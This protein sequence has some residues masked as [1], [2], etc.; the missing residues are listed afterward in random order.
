MMKA[1]RGLSLFGGLAVVLT[2]FFVMGCSNNTP[3]QPN[4]ANPLEMGNISAKTISSPSVMSVETYDSAYIDKEVGGDIEIQRGDYVHDFAVAADGL[5]ESTLITVRSANDQILGKE[6]I[7]FEF[8]PDGLVF[9]K[10]ASLQFDMAELGTQSTVAKLYYYD[11]VKGK[12]SF[13]YSVSV[14]NGI[15]EFSIDHF[16]KYAISD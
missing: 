5:S 6:M 2:L 4:V 8:G 16:S 13:Q 15:A 12:W 10:S 14:Q 9:K 11:P 7:V 1:L 3:M